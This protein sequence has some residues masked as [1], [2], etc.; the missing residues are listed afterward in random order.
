MHTT[1]MALS[2]FKGPTYIDDWSA[3]LDSRWPERRGVRE[4]IVDSIE[5]WQASFR[6][7]S[8]EADPLRLIELGVG[9]GQLAAAVIDRICHAVGKVI[10]TGV[11]INHELTQFA[12]GRL[13][14]QSA[15]VEMVI[16]DLNDSES[17]TDGSDVDVMF[18]LQ[19]LHDLDGYE[20]LAAVYDASGRLLSP[21]G[22]LLNADFIEPF[23]KDDPAHPRR[24]PVEVHETLLR[25]L[26][27]VDFQYVVEGKLAS[28][29]ARRPE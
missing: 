3:D 13:G 12:L 29:T 14:K 17:L 7:T 16:A 6:P 9:N 5:A 22:L 20:A 2:D 8:A 1:I 11:D 25:E 26:G 27:F 21:S 18:T 23:E 24:F 10:Y 19:T 15:S 4:R 28:M